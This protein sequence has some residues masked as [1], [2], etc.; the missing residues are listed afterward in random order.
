[1]NIVKWVRLQ[2][3]RCLS[4]ACIAAG[5]I[6]LV[7][8]YFGVSSTGFP[9]AQ[10]PYIISGGIGGLFLLGVGGMLWLSADL[11]DEWRKLDLIEKVMRQAEGGEIAVGQNSG[12]NNDLTGRASGR[13]ASRNDSEAD[14]A[15]G[16]RV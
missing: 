16:S 11:R 14:E 13:I 7:I 5:V 4:W 9:A 2:W 15:L 3:D 6:I 1:M 10:S 12:S 8:G